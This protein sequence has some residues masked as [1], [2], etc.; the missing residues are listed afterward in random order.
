MK[1]YELTINTKEKEADAL[2]EK[3]V[4]CLPGPVVRQQKDSSFLSLEF[5]SEPEKI[6]ELEK[7]LKENSLKYMILAKK[8]ATFI[9]KG[10]EKPVIARKKIVK[11][12]V[13]LKEIDEKLEE[14]LK[15]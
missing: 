9:K 15:E 7:K 10:K 1:Y 11:P 12:K 2:L 14:I 6:Q 5:Y 3:A 13:E 4:S 8:P